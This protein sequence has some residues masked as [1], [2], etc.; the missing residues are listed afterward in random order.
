[1][2]DETT[3]RKIQELGNK[4]TIE[5]NESRKKNPQRFR[6]WQHQVPL[7]VEVK[8]NSTKRITREAVFRSYYHRL[9]IYRWGSPGIVL[10]LGMVLC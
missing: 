9:D 10:I 3:G 1:M 7:E 6:N 4:W 8:G 5:K 2:G